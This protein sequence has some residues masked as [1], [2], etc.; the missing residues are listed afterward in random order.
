MAK[1]ETVKVLLSSAPPAQK[2]LS[3]QDVSSAPSVPSRTTAEPQLCG[4]CSGCSHES[5]GVL[6]MI[7]CRAALALLVLEAD[8][9][10][11]QTRRKFTSFQLLKSQ[12]VLR[13]WEHL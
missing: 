10:A 5:C 3:P 6:P 2:A 9:F 13:W 7:L 1:Q 8:L 11:L 12:L 4:T